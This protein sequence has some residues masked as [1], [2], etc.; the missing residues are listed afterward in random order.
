MSPESPFP[1][2]EYD[3][4][5]TYFKEKYDICVVNKKQPLIKVKSLGVSKINF[6]TPR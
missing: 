2:G 5:G 4:F 1:N 3:T 6:L